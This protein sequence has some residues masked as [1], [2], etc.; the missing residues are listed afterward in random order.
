MC[1]KGPQSDSQ[2]P[3]SRPQVS[4]SGTK[5]GPKCPSGHSERY[6]PKV[7]LDKHLNKNLIRDCVKNYGIPTEVAW[8][9]K[10][11]AKKQRQIYS[12]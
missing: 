5:S 11:F 7:K 9:E 12:G 6:G 10:P 3:Q 2:V 4:Q 1:T 8:Y